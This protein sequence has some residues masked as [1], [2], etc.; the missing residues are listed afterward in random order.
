[1][2]PTTKSS[3]FDAHFLDRLV[4]TKVTTFDGIHHQVPS[5]FTTTPHE[6]GRPTTASTVATAPEGLLYMGHH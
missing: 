4:G 1:M 3:D 2:A 5:A 6:T